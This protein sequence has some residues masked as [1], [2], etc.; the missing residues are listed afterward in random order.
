MKA[1]FQKSNVTIGDVIIYH[2]LRIKLTDYIINNNP[3]IF[4]IT[5]KDKD[6]K[7]YEELLF[8]KSSVWS[9]MKDKYPHL[10]WLQIFK[11][12]AEDIN[13]KDFTDGRFFLS[14]SSF[15]D[16][17]KILQHVSGIYNLVYFTSRKKA[18]EALQLMGNNIKYVV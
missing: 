14:Y 10:Y 12:I 6:L 1:K 17:I 15:E 9:F 13:S 8:T 18:E 2:N 5:K 7:K 11:L 4:V 3:E 16:T